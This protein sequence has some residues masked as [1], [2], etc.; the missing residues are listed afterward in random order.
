MI[1][2]DLP[3]SLDRID[4]FTGNERAP[5][6]F[7]DSRRNAVGEQRQH[8]IQ[9]IERMLRQFRLDT[10]IGQADDI[11]TVIR[12]HFSTDAGKRVGRSDVDPDGIRARHMSCSGHRFAV[13]FKDKLNFGGIR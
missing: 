2:L 13:L 7:L 6:R 12:A 4:L 11:R 8:K 9:L 5:G 1:R 3:K 10:G